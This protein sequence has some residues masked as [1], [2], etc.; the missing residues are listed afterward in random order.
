MGLTIALRA[1]CGYVVVNVRPRDRALVGLTG[2]SS[3]M[4]RDRRN[5]EWAQIP[6]LEDADDIDVV[7]EI[8][9]MFWIQRRDMSTGQVCGEGV[10]ADAR[11]RL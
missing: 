6:L 4:G 11:T 8:R 1:E 3:E 10:T 5:D 7:F 9:L 2:N